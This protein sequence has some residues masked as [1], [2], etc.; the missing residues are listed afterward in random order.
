MVWYG[1]SWH[2]WNFYCT[3]HYV[4]VLGRGPHLYNSRAAGFTTIYQLFGKHV[5]ITANV[6]ERSKFDIHWG[7]DRGDVNKYY[8]ETLIWRTAIKVRY[9]T[10]DITLLNKTLDG[11]KVYALVYSSEDDSRHCGRLVT[12]RAGG[13]K[14]QMHC[15]TLY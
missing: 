15:R 11:Y 6:T 8:N 3:C 10:M 1:C 4:V 5:R 13:K 7:I 2:R 12:I 14:E 9:Q